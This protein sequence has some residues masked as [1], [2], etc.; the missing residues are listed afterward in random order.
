MMTLDRDPCYGIDAGGIRRITAL[1]L[2]R[3]TLTFVRGPRR[4]REG[5]CCSHRKRNR[6]LSP[7]DAPRAERRGLAI[8]DVSGRRHLSCV[9]QAVGRA[10]P[11]LLARTGELWKEFVLSSAEALAAALSI[12]GRADAALRGPRKFA[13]GEQFFILTEPL[14][15]YAQARDSAAW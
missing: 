4:S 5:W 15:A 11:Y 12:F 14:E 6:A 1:R 2:R 3:S 9:P 10:L 13:W 7:A 8:I